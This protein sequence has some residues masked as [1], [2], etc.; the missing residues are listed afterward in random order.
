MPPEKSKPPINHETRARV[1]SL[2]QAAKNRDADVDKLL[3][4]QRVREGA[5]QSGAL[6]GFI[7]AVFAFLEAQFPLYELW[8]AVEVVIAAFIGAFGGAI[9][10]GLQHKR[11]AK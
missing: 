5:I 11:K 6:V 2:E 9:L 8:N 10:S 4:G 1:N 3:R 7:T